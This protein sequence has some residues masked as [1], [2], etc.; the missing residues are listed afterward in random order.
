M[1]TPTERFLAQNKYLAVVTPSGNNVVERVTA[2]VL[3]HF[4]AV[5]PLHS[6]TPVFGTSDPF[7]DSYD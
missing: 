4:P 7:P 3:S 2:G 6:R 1:A 5:V